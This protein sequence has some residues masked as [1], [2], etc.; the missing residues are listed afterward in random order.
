MPSELH[1]VAAAIRS[2]FSS[3][4]L[5]DGT[6]SRDG[7]TRNDRRALRSILVAWSDKP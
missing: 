7:S 1:Q 3:P 5:G 2:V 4:K 6:S